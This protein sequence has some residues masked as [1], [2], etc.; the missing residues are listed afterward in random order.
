MNKK[1]LY[2][3]DNISNMKITKRVIEHM[4]HRFAWSIN[5]IQ[6]LEFANLYEPDLI[7]LDITLPDLDGFEV[8]IRLRSSDNLSLKSVPIIALTGRTSKYDVLRAMEVGFNE[9]MFKP[10][11]LRVLMA[12]VENFLAKEEPAHIS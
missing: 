3:E 7:L 12:R 11:D 1:V 9:Y 4:G 8:A 10:V 2:V 5:G 6:G